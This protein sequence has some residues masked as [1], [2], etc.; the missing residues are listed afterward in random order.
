MNGSTSPGIEA[1]IA[2]TPLQIG[3]TDQ[4]DCL[5][6]RGTVWLISGGRSVARV[7]GEWCAP[8]ILWVFLF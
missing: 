8:A 4:S 1:Q 5:S 7:G 6:S 2:A 3:A